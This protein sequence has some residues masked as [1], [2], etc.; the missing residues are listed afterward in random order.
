V[1][2]APA[3]SW[4]KRRGE[5]GSAEQKELEAASRAVSEL[6][7]ALVTAATDAAELMRKGMEASGTLSFLGNIAG[8]GVCLFEK[9][10]RS[11]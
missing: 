8:F 11:V 2:L 5:E 1:T 10:K 6:S 9:I 7:K 4:A 3:A